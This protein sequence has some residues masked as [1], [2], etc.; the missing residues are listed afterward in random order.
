MVRTAYGNDRIYDGHVENAE[1]L[2]R[3]AQLP[4]TEQPGT[5]W[6]YGQ[7]N[8]QGQHLGTV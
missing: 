7:S 6:D 3:I 4:I 1:Y 2:E 8:D 5:L